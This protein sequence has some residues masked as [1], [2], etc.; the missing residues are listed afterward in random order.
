MTKTLTPRMLRQI[1]TKLYNETKNLTPEQRAERH[2][3]TMEN[4]WKTV[5]EIN[6]EKTQKTKTLKDS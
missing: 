4:F 5:A 1:R 6:A 2:R 3:I